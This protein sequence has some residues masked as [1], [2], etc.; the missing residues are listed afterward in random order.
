MY[1]DLRVKSPIKWVVAFIGDFKGLM[2]LTSTH[3]G[4]EQHNTNLLVVFVTDE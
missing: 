1:Q 2:S 3:L 4:A